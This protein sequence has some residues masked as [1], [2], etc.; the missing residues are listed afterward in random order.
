MFEMRKVV[1]I[2]ARLSSSRL[3]KKVLLDLKGK[4][5]IQRVYEQV[6]KAKKI[7]AIY[8]ASDSLEVEREC[9]SFTSN[10]I[11][12]SSK[13]ESGT[14]RIA[15]AV[16]DI[17]CDI[18]INVQGD[19]PFIEPLLID[20]FA[21][22]FE[23]EFLDMVSAMHKISLVD[24]LKNPNIVKVIVNKNKEA[25]YF[26]RS[27]IPH[28]RD[29]WE[30][31]LKHHVKVPKSLKFYRHLGIYGYT[32]K[33]LLKYIRLDVSYLERLEKLEQLRVIENGYK[34]KMIETNYDSIGIDTEDDYKKALELIN[35]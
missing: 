18:V 9:K 32:K 16:Q 22:I 12:T 4:S 30:I 20:E 23:K 34:I 2:P 35:E 27:V 6:K 5:V 29:E 11:L 3:P 7:D 33:F 25:I 14:D 15:E 17:E 24:E 13:H 28:H 8:I 19:E 10:I 26:S 31:L 21:D 1:I